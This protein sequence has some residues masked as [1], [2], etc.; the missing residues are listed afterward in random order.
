MSK[1]FIFILLATISTLLLSNKSSSAACSSYWLDSNG[2]QHCLDGLSGTTNRKKFY[3]QGT[4]L[5]L[6]ERNVAAKHGFS[7]Q[8]LQNRKK[9]ICTHAR[10]GKSYAYTMSI[11]FDDLFEVSNDFESSHEITKMIMA[12][13]KLDY[14]NDQEHLYTPVLY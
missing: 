6:F 1:N 7:Y 10:R 9:L 4:K 12:T 2:E 8:K 5:E 11:L 14:C 13:S 3:T